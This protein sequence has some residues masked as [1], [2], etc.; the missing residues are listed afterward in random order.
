MP[1]A[2]AD[3][4]D[5]EVGAR[6]RMRRKA[7]RISQTELAEAIGL[8]FQQVQKYESG[9]NRVSASVLV[10]MGKKLDCTVAWLVGEDDPDPAQNEIFEN[11]VLPGATE[12][13]TAYA[14]L[15]SLEVRRAV[16]ALVR[17]MAAEAQGGAEDT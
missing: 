2:P 12:L 16:L 4:I 3:P 1:E 11:L 7:M 17:T 9:A 5:I 13:L 15:P 6:I 8:S 10:R 14:A